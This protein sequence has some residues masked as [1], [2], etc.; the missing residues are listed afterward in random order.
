MS[1]K[2]ILSEDHT[3]MLAEIFNMGMGRSLGALSNITGKDHEITFSTPK[4]EVIGKDDFF[5]KV[6]EFKRM[7]M[8]AQDYKGEIRGTAI[9]YLPTAAGKELAR[10][11]IGTEISIDQ[12][13]KLESD[14]LIEIGNI[15]INSSIS[16]L[17]NFLNISIETKVPEMI[18]PDRILS[19]LK[20][21][22]EIIHLNAKFNIAHLKLE[23]Q[24]AFVLDN[25]S[26]KKLIQIIDTYLGNF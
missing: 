18:F 8:I 11:L 6:N 1:N 19:W 14:A 23:G 26:I 15:F 22:D 3:D 4:V 24:V 16:C 5:I 20:G 25:E 9:F 7:A 17:A 12:I 10:L 13:E 2:L 21:S